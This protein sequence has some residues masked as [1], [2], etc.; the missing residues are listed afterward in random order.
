M[1]TP[2]SWLPLQVLQTPPPTAP[3]TPPQYIHSTLEH[4]APRWLSNRTESLRS[5]IYMYSHASHYIQQ[6]LEDT[7]ELGSLYTAH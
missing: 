5:A 3:Q 1:Y 6:W 2:L 7:T 4:S